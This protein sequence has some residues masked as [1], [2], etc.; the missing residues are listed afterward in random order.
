MTSLRSQTSAPVPLAGR[1]GYSLPAWIYRDAEFLA[2]EK[3]RLFMPSWQLVC[4]ASDL[5]RAGDYHGYTI[6]GELAFVVRGRDGRLRAFHNVCRHRAARLLD[7]DRG[8]CRANIVCPYHAWSY[9]LDGRLVGVPFHDEYEHF[10]PA[11]HAL[12]PLECDSFMGFVFVRFEPGGPSL[13]DTMAPAAAEMALYRIETMQ[14][15]DQV[16]T[17]AREVNWKKRHRQ[18]HR[19]PARARRASGTRQP[20]RQQ[21]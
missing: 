18:L 3:E 8:H 20:G 13:A 4:H 21:L 12:V 19:R 15:L 7:G 17:R 2:L 11:T 1:G 10:D 14:P 16:R 9:D 5:P 6:L